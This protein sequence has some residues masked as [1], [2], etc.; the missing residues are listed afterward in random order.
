MTDGLPPPPPLLAVRLRCG[1]FARESFLVSTA[2]VTFAF[3][4]ALAFGLGL[5]L[6][7]AVSSGL[8]SL[9]LL[10]RRFFAPLRRLGLCAFI[11]ASKPSAAA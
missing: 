11:N 9:P 7:V 3:A 5:D 10:T 8:L 6:A 1:F 2:A 4:F